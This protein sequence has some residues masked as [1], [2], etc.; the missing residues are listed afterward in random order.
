[1]TANV[2]FAS[3]K[4]SRD[5]GSPALANVFISMFGDDGEASPVG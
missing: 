3:R 2:R 1:M 5:P 4:I